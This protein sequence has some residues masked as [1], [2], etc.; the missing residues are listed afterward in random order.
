MTSAAFDPT[1]HTENRLR[2]CAQLSTNEWVEFGD[3]R[4]ALGVS[5]PTLSKHITVLMGARYV[6]QSR[7]TRDT[8]QRVW[9]RLTASGQAAY[10]AHLAALRAIVGADAL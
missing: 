1:I 6:E 3:V 10:A 9:L 2:I 8:R 5:D 4:A 7:A